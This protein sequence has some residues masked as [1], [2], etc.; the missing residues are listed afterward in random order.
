M[1]NVPAKHEMMVQDIKCG[2][3]VGNSCR[4]N[5]TQ[6]VVSVDNFNAYFIITF[7]GDMARHY[8]ERGEALIE[9]EA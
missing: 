4:V 7:D 3:V 9:S 5:M 6:K 2:D 8:S 1:E